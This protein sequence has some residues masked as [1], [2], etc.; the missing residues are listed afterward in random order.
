[1]WG[2]SNWCERVILFSLGTVLFLLLS[3]LFIQSTIYNV[4]LFLY[5]VSVIV[6][7]IWVTCRDIQFLLEQ[8]AP[9]KT[10]LQFDISSKHSKINIV[11]SVIRILKKILIGKDVRQNKNEIEQKK[12]AINMSSCS[13]IST[14][15]SVIERKFVWAWYS[16]YVS[17]EIAFPF[18]CK[19]L[20]DQMVTKIFQVLTYKFHDDGLTEQCRMFKLVTFR[21]LKFCFYI[22]IV[23]EIYKYN[24]VLTFCVNPI[25]RTGKI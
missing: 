14:I 1:M 25:Y 18:A 21:C 10:E 7:S 4:W 11:S 3:N 15:A 24:I 19:E 2:R 6:L 17:K 23:F 8:S 5:T 9:L 16:Q 20:L 13:D 12:K 22:L